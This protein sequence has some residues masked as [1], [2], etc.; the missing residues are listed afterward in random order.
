MHGGRCGIC[1]EFVGVT[2]FE[3]DHVV[4]LARGGLHGYV[5]TQPS[6]PT[7][8]RKKYDHLQKELI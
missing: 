5:N 2:D 7:C 3:I 4:P 8:N 1:G 6:H